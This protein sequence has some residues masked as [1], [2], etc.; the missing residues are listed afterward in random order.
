MARKKRSIVET[1]SG[2]IFSDLGFPDPER[3]RIKAQLTLQI[4]RI[5]K[6]RGLTQ[7]A[8]GAILGIRQPHVSAL[9]RGRSGT[10]SAERLMEFLVALGHDVEVS[11]RP[12]RRRAGQMSVAV[13]Q[14]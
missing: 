7:T 13:R 12:A 8:A 5:I 9:M 6:A 4:Y 1:S 10:Y 11:I 2:N 14:A 3:E